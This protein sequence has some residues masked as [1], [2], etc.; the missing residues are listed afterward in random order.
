MPLRLRADLSL[1][2]VAILWG[3]AFAAQRM[4]GLLGS[5]YSFNGARFMVA[6]LVLL[7]FSVMTKLKPRQ[8]LWMCAAGIVLFLGSALQQAGLLTTSAGDAGFLTSLYVVLVPIVMLVGWRERPHVLAV[9]AVLM[10]G[11]GAYLLS[12]PG[13][14]ALQPGDA[15]E[16]AG[17]ACRAVHVVLVG[18][19]A[20]AYESLSFSA[21]QL[22]VASV[23]NWIAC[24][25]FE[26]PAFPPLADVTGAI[27]YT[28]PASL[29]IGYSLQI[30]AQKH[31]P[32][33]DAA[34]ILSLESVFAAAAGGYVLGE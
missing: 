22:F 28:A 31:T 17:A 16:L 29:A 3:S 12:T 32:P 21:G 1:L 26:A 20:S 34:I 10:A 33:T 2:L 4:A 30:W 8:W 14:F 25:L 7:P 19:F 18:K 13:R 6:G 27:L 23:F 9:I 11:A 24:A 5:V 15:L